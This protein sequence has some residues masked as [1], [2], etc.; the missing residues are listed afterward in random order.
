LADASAQDLLGNDL[1]IN[2]TVEE[3][4]LKEICFGV[5]IVDWILYVEKEKNNSELNIQFKDKKHL[6]DYFLSLKPPS[7]ALKSPPRSLKRP[8]KS[9]A[10]ISI[11][12]Q[13]QNQ[14]LS[15]PIQPSAQLTA[16]V[17][18]FWHIQHYELEDEKHIEHYVEQETQFK[19]TYMVPFPFFENAPVRKKPWEKKALID[20]TEEKLSLIS[21]NPGKHRQDADEPPEVAVPAD[22][23]NYEDF[24]TQMESK[25]SDK[26][27]NES[28]AFQ[29][30]VVMR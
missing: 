3:L 21:T 18:S 6:I 11:S 27:R 4:D 2:K 19:Y 22:I 30:S 16:Q 9:T 24:I 1:D 12:E 20:S 25:I 26:K 13:L 7:S 23:P 14:K 5:N 28:Q 15:D 29:V 8:I 10:E 17:T